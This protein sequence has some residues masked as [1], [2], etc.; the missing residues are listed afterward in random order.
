MAEQIDPTRSI[1]PISTVQQDG[2]K[3][4]QQHERTRNHAEDRVSLGDAE[5]VGETYG[6]GL[7][8]ASP[9]EL[10]RNLVIKTLQEQGLEL[11]VNLGEAEVDFNTMS[12]EEAQELISEDGYFGVEKTSQRIVDFAVNAFGS[13]PA[14]LDQMKDAIDQGFLDAQEAFG[15]ALPE[16]S[17]QTYDAIMEKLDVFAAQSEE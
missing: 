10:L 2:M 6:P 16:I 7:K 9:Y 13:D 14:K 11:Q 4:Q 8:V 15:G 5:T 1:K 17:Q 12:Q 3:P